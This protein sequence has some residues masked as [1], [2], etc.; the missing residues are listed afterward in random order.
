MI[1]SVRLSP[2][3][4][5]RFEIPRSISSLQFFCAE[6]DSSFTWKGLFGDDSDGY[7]AFLPYYCG[8]IQGLGSS[9]CQYDLQI[10][11]SI[12]CVSRFC[13]SRMY[14]WE[15]SSMLSRTENVEYSRLKNELVL[16]L[17]GWETM[18]ERIFEEVYSIHV[19]DH[20]SYHL[21]DVR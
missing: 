19:Y 13:G 1:R 20:L 5:R 8:C 12:V 15:G 6:Y 9:Y 21:G 10:G 16:N 3:A 11:S 2:T 7:K 18:K 17:L 4:F 14:H